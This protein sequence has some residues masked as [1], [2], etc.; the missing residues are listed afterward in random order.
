M[1]ASISFNPNIT[2]VSTGLFNIQSGGLTQ[3]T[4]FPDPAIRFKLAAGLL[5]TTE[6]LP[7]WGGVGIFTNIPGISGGPSIPLGTIVGRA[8]SAANLIAFSVFDQAYGMINTPQSPAPLA[9]SGMQV[10]YYRLGSGARIAVKASPALRAY[11]G[12]LTNIQVSWDFVNQQLIPYI[13][14]YASAAVSSATYNSTTGI[15][16]LTFS[17]A[18]FGAGVGSTLNG[19]YIS[20]SGLAGTGV[21]PL[22]GDWPITGTASS[23]TVISVQGPTG[24]GALTI[25][26]STGTLAAG[27]GALA[28]QVLQV[29]NGSNGQSVSYNATT[30]FATWNFA[31]NL[32][33]ILI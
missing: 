28:C 7:M 10:M 13:A 32:A 18:P 3:G 17:P 16:A 22:N 1:V 30:G 8:T 14:A 31:D 21:A 5:A 26:G 2:T 23:G 25:T 24:L 29:E 4:A 6:T 15:I 27:G 11:Q 9:A 20:I 12:D 19:A 33:L